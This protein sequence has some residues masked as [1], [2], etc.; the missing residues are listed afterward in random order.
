MSRPTLVF[1]KGPQEGQKL[2]I[3][4]KQAV[5]GRAPQCELQLKED[6]VSRQQMRFTV[7]D[8]GCIMENMSVNGTMVNG[9]RYKAG[10]QIMLATG[11][12][13]GVGLET[14]ILFVS[15]GD[16]VQQA[17][18]EH[19]H[20]IVPPVPETARDEFP[21]PQENQQH[22]YEPAEPARHSPPP[23]VELTPEELAVKAQK[24]KYRKYVIMLGISVLFT[25]SLIVVVA[26]FKPAGSAP[27]LK[28][29]PRLSEEQIR[30][31]LEA[32]PDL[33]PNSTLAAD[34][35]VKARAFYDN[36]FRVGNQYMCIKYYKLH[37]AYLGSPSFQ[38]ADE[39]R[40]R[41]ALN[42]LTQG[43]EGL[44]QKVVREYNKAMEF[45]QA[46]RWR[47][48]S[49]ALEQI[50]QMVP[51]QDYR[52]PTYEQLLTNIFAHKNYVTLKMPSKKK[53]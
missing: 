31:A 38:P 25:V 26:I 16:D 32:R 45:E 4:G 29:L 7:G 40:Y 53:R 37:L 34:S 36:H 19:A 43:P 46:G 20:Q 22:S 27:S 1:I 33:S 51:E 39:D 28:S 42:G 5:A 10:K 47:E 8:D 52:D 17:I 44:V 15:P 50:L 21:P 30:H 2:P 13:L 49:A 9:K 6:Y 35:L 41:R 18:D 24:A 11:D 23:E 48:A 12:V 14:E 3:D